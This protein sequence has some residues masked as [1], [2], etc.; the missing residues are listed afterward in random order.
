MSDS[1]KQEN[2]DQPKDL[3]NTKTKA[4]TSGDTQATEKVS[5]EPAAKSTIKSKEAVKPNKSPD[6][7]KAKPKAE[8]VTSEDTKSGK[9]GLVLALVCLLLIIGLAGFSHYRFEQLSTKLTTESQTL[10]TAISTQAGQFDIQLGS[11]T[12]DLNRAQQDRESQ[13]I[14]FERL[15]AKLTDAIKQVEAGQ[16]TS[17]SD[18]RLAEVEY[19]LRLA[20][21]RVLTE[22]RPEGAL[23]LLRT[24]D[25][26]IRELDDVTLFNLR[27]AIANE[28]VNL[29]AVPKLDI[30][31]TYLR[32]SA[33]IG[34]AG[35]LA[36]LSVEQQR[37][38]PDMLKEITPDLIDETL[39]DEVQS[40]LASAMSRLESLI[41]IQHHDDPIEPL[42]SPEE[43][44]QLRQSVQLFLSQTQLALLR[45][46]QQI[47]NRS[48]EEAEKLIARYFDTKSADTQA[49]LTAINELKPLQVATEMPDISGSLSILQ[50]HIAELTKLGSEARK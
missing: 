33:M 34:Q 42:L 7:P 11:I 15:Q 45:Q 27:E 30:E 25:K 12:D 5:P 41:I 13:I 21:Q 38:L 22:K 36:T 31:G 47:F 44:T 20:N 39:R 10:K 49:I 28:I 50:A 46:Q 19:L 8:S 32:L 1:P 17:D 23:S 9:A 4:S 6:K 14:L 3:K 40:S 29:E 24:S 48:L 16:K 2:T 43:G 18:W 35:R 37:E 26:I